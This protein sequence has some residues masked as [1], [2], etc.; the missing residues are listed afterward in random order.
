MITVGVIAE[1]NPFHKGHAYLFEQA[2][3]L[4][5][6]DRVIVV[7]SGDFVQRGAPAVFDKYTRTRMAL[8]GGADAVI[9][10]PVIY[11][12]ASAG[13]FAR[14]GIRIFD[15]L[16]CVDYVC[17]GSECG[18]IATLQSASKILSNES[19]EFRETLA[20][21]CKNGMSYPAA[22]EQ[23]FR[24]CTDDEELIKAIS[25]P[26]NI[27]AIEY[28]S[29]LRESGSSMIPVTVKRLGGGYHEERISGALSSATAIRS[30]MDGAISAD[31]FAKAYS[32]F[33]PESVIA[34]I[35]NEQK[36][37]LTMTE[38]DFSMPLFMKLMEH[39]SASL[40]EYS[41]VT[42]EMADSCYSHRNQAKSFSDTVAMLKNKSITYTT[43]S[44]ALLHIVLGIKK[45]DCKRAVA[46][47][48][49]VRLLGFNREH[50]DVCR[51]M[52]DNLGDK[53]ITKPADADRSNPV[54]KL[55]IAAADIYNEAVFLK[56]GRA[57]VE[58]MKSGPVVYKC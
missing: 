43:V 21:A 7:M 6:A 39:D 20:R 25:L 47:V 30:M 35:V 50:S 51:V 44:R 19:D 24:S 31:T 3:A 27:L 33:V 37:L 42:R 57:P 18:D 22:R 14:A 4:T 56:Y 28:I 41:D 15:S 5:G 54:L 17:F 8:A 26:N 34:D 2:R 36:S 38:N 40:Q 58:E 12:T 29:A 13:E 1:F 10:L 32:Q 53:F 16:G 55:D 9:E 23:A 48:D 11:A 45:D 46:G 49:Y 52:S